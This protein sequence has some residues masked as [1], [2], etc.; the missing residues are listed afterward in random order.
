[1]L[2]TYLICYFSKKPKNVLAEKT[3]SMSMLMEDKHCTLLPF[4]RVPCVGLCYL[5]KLLLSQGK[6][7]INWKVPDAK[8]FC[9]LHAINWLL[10]SKPGE[11]RGRVEKESFRRPTLTFFFIYSLNP[12]ISGSSYFLLH[13][14]YLLP[15][16]IYC[17]VW[18]VDYFMP[19]IYPYCLNMF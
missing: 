9:I 15:P 13:K 6:K 4:A 2:P 16:I 18:L 5:N 10:R 17:I 19:F 14:P 7:G 1:M 11:S 8:W 3:K 12:G